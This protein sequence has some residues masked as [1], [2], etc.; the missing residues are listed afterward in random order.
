MHN[1]SDLW[2]HFRVAELVF[3]TSYE[4]GEALKFV[5]LRTACLSLAFLLFHVFTRVVRV[6][7]S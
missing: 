7:L 5:Y 4:E 3:P 2:N 1:L 6:Q